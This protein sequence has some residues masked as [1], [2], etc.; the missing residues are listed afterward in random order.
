MT[1]AG[2]HDLAPARVARRVKLVFV[3]LVIGGSSNN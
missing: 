1:E 2:V 3:F